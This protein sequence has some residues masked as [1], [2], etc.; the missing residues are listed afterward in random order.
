MRCQAEKRR[1]TVH[2]PARRGILARFTQAPPVP[3]LAPDGLHLTLMLERRRRP[4]IVRSVQCAVMAAVVV[5]AGG[6]RAS[7]Q[8]PTDPAPSRAVLDR[9]CVSCHNQR[10]RTA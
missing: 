9:Y 1:D 7:L 3:D 8:A 4:A 10:T 6:R 5:T 2:V